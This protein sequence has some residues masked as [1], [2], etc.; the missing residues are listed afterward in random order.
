MAKSIFAEAIQY[1]VETRKDARIMDEQTFRE[2]YTKERKQLP[3]VAPKSFNQ[4]IKLYRSR[5]IKKGSTEDVSLLSAFSYIP[6]EKCDEN[7]PKLQRSN[8]S[9]ESIFYGSLSPETIFKETNYDKHSDEWALISCWET[10][11]P[12][13]LFPPA[14]AILKQIEKGNCPKEIPTELQVKYFSL[15]KNIMQEDGV[16]KATYLPSANFCKHIF[17]ADF[18]SIEDKRLHQKFYDGI[19]YKSVRDIPDGYN[20]AIKKEIVDQK[21]Q[22]KFVIRANK[23]KDKSLNF[24][25]IGFFENGKVKWY[26]IFVM[27][28][29]IHVNNYVFMTQGKVIDTTKGNIFDSEGKIIKNPISIFKVDSKDWMPRFFS[30]TA[31]TFDISEISDKQ[32]FEKKYEFY[33]RRE[34][35][36][37][38]YKDDETMTDI[39][40]IIFDFS[41]SVSL[42]EVPMNKMEMYKVVK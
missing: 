28:E 12:L 21:L 7:F 18:S 38:T 13:G 1:L 4:G 5:S 16:D 33:L 14:D 20:F 36:G 3:L 31:S 17:E 29:S 9:G 24:D 37:W 19:L 32:S 30:S 10:V 40:S 15:I 42:H 23:K 27:R 2:K 34:F 35:D 6:K 39:D 8:F 41:F 26:E 25:Q 22:L 11:A